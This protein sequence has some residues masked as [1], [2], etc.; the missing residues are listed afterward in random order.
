MV[1]EIQYTSIKR[2]LDSLTEHPLLRDVS[3]EQVIRYVIRFIELNGYPKLYQD[4]IEHVKI[5]DFRGIMPCDLISI[6]QVKDCCS[7]V[8]LRAMTDNFPKGLKKRSK[9]DKTSNVQKPLDAIIPQDGMDRMGELYISPRKECYE[10]PSFKTQGRVIYTSFPEGD[11]EIAYKAI[12]MDEEGFPMLIDN[13][14]YIAALEAYIKKQIFTI[15]F[16][17]GKISAQVL[18]NAKQEYAWLAGECK[19]EFVMPS[20]SEFEAISRSLMS[21]IPRVREFD[22]GFKNLGSREYLRNHR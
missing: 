8:C 17:T 1:K 15:K 14:V 16:D 20:V 12:P 13:E 6:I 9:T 4:K 22:N 2:V 21:L 7:G 11:I 10:E 18:Q 5:E 19:A 3:L